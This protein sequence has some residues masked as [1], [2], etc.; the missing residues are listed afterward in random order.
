MSAEGHGTAVFTRLQDEFREC[1]KR[2]N[3]MLTEEKTRA[4]FLLRQKLQKSNEVLAKAEELKLKSGRQQ[5]EVMEYS[6]KNLDSES[7]PQYRAPEY[8]L[9]WVA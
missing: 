6:S 5:H 3:C 2:R 9:F 4:A 7:I 1:T 8:G